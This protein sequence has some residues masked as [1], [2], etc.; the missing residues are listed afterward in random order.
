VGRVKVFSMKKVFENESGAGFIFFAL[1]AMAL[2]FLATDIYLP[3]LPAIRQSFQAS[4]YQVQ[5]T[6]STYMFGLALAQVITGPFIDHVGCRKL[7]LLT[8]AAFILLSL[9]C[10]ASVGVVYLTAFRALQGFLAGMIGVTARAS[11]I[12]RFSSERTQSIFMTYGPWVILTSVI[13]PGLGGGIVH[14]MG[15][16]AVFGFLSIYGMLVFVGLKYNFFVRDVG[17]VAQGWAWRKV[18]AGYWEVLSHRQFMG[19]LMVNAMYLA[20]VFS[21]AVEAPFIFHH[22]G[23]SAGEIG[24]SFVPMALAFLLSSQLNRLFISQYLKFWH[25]VLIAFV[26]VLLGMG[27][28]A[29]AGSVFDGAVSMMVG[30][31]I[32]AF[33]MGFS[34][35]AAFGRAITFMPHRSGYAA[36]VVSAI[37]FAFGSVLTLIVHP[38]CGN[39]VLLLALFLLGIA[40]ICVLAYVL[41]CLNALFSE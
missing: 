39:N 4:I 41:L 3:A 5:H 34:S 29:T 1:F 31:S 17:Q 35:P 27:V 20:I 8:T 32:A 33:G 30:M 25:M 6:L 2:A 15:W 21:F 38:V 36:S 14:V 16:R 23:Y 40:I 22:L 37:P 10:A 26:G 13:A 9:A 18:W 24:V 7:I 11:F 19:C 28:L 12:Q